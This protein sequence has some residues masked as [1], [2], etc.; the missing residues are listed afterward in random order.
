MPGARDPNKALASFWM[1]KDIYY[2]LGI[3]SKVSDTTVTRFI[4]E[5]LAEKMGF[6]LDEAGNPVGLDLESLARKAYEGRK[7]PARKKKAEPARG[8]EGEMDK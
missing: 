6:T 2:A 3:I 7:R 5:A 4:L 8:P 1:H